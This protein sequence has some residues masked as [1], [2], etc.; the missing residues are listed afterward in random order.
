MVQIR[1]NGQEQHKSHDVDGQLLHTDLLGTVR[2]FVCIIN[3]LG[4]KEP[5]P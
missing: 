4:I 1:E 2:M 5:A 3:L